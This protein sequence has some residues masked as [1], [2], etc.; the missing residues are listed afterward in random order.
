MQVRPLVPSQSASAVHG[1]PVVPEETTIVPLAVIC[2]AGPPA[3]NIT[4]Y[5]PGCDHVTV[6]VVALELGGMPI[7][8][9]HTN[10][11]TP[12][13]DGT[14][15]TVKGT[16]PVQRKS[17]IVV[18]SRVAQPIAVNAPRRGPGASP[19]APSSPMPMSDVALASG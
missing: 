6:G 14:K 15:V 17:P 4:W 13:P 1:E 18:V 9:V 2:P 8:N 3:A 10:V 7:A 19:K 5:T 11:L 16:R 12:D